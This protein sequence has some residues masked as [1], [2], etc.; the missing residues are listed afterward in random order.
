VRSAFY[1]SHQLS[2]RSGETEYRVYSIYEIDGP[3]SPPDEY[4]GVIV[5]TSN[6]RDVNMPCG[7]IP[8]N[9]LASLVREFSVEYQDGESEA[10]GM[11]RASFQMCHAMPFNSNDG[12]FKAGVAE[13]EIDPL[14]EAF[15]L[16]LHDAP[17]IIELKD[18][19]IVRLVA[20]PQHGKLSRNQ[21]NAAHEANWRYTPARGFVGDDRAEFAVRG[22]TKAGQMA[23]FRLVYRLRVT[24]KKL[25]A[26]IPQPRPPQLS[27]DRTYCLIP[28]VLVDYVGAR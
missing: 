25:A 22:K 14:G 27:V 20:K 23:A 5:G 16:G 17:E 4:G 11:I 13:Y 12:D 8:E 15:M 26:F 1:E 7:S 9:G 18:G 3:N 24:P 2:F 19:A 6:G 10:D 21:K 28:T